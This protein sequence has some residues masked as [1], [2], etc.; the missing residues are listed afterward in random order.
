MNT[1]IAYQILEDPGFTVALFCWVEGI[2]PRLEADE[3][4]HTPGLTCGV[5]EPA[6]WVQTTELSE[7]LP[8]LVFAPTVLDDDD[9]I[10]VVEGSMSLEV[11]VAWEKEKAET[12]L[13]LETGI[14]LT[15]PSRL[16][17]IL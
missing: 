14:G 8:G 11:C 15:A 16:D 1:S 7:L 10:C 12:E 3:L 5:D 2:T 13:E 4:K 6:I 9:G 17:W